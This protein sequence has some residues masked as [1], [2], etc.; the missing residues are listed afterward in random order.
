M[1]A[2]IVLGNADLLV[3]ILSFTVLRRV[4]NH[5]WRPLPDE[6]HRMLRLH[7]I[8]R[9]QHV[10]GGHALLDALELAPATRERIEARVYRQTPQRHLPDGVF[11]SAK[12]DRES[13]TACAQHG[14]R[15]IHFVSH[16]F[17]DGELVTTWLAR[18]GVGC[19]RTCGESDMFD[20]GT[21]VYT[22]AEIE[23]IEAEQQQ[24]MRACI[25][26]GRSLQPIIPLLEEYVPPHIHERHLQRGAA[27]GA[28][29][30]VNLL[31]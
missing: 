24:Q 3:H 15:D 14:P 4:L 11:V 8:V 25:R 5:G 16:C 21:R 28:A 1:A 17:F 22:P 19:W 29:P 10:D 6:V 31:A 20:T 13:R 9:G 2:L 7:G 23:R 26:R 12:M 27:A 18:A 30:P